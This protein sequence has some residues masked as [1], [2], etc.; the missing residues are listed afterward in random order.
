M[1]VVESL[2]VVFESDILIQEDINKLENLSINSETDGVSSR[3]KRAATANKEFLWDFGV[4]P[5]VIDESVGFDSSEKARFRAAME[6]WE[7]VSCIKF[8]ERNA[9]EHDNFIRFTKKSCGC[10]SYV[11]KRWID[12]YSGQDVSIGDGCH[13]KGIILHELGH[14]IGFWHEHMRFDRDEFIKIQSEYIQNGFEF[15]FR[16]LTT[17]DVNSL[18]EPY[19]FDSI[20]HYRPE[21]FSI[22]G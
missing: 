1:A 17:K 20:M 6:D 7:S 13:N 11:G 5:Y 15:A 3:T 22:N 9:N 4:I 2:P 19:D 18:G 14:V 12:I 8:V 10:C 21:S 16:K